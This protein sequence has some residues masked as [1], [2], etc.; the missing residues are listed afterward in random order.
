MSEKKTFVFNRLYAGMLVSLFGSAQAA[1]FDV[2]TVLDT[3]D[4]NPGDGV[5]VDAAGR[6]SLRAAIEESV[7]LGGSH[8]IN[9]AAALVASSDQTITLSE[10]DDGL[11][12]GEYGATAFI[13]GNN[14]TIT[15]NGPTG[16]NGVTVQRTATS[17]T[18]F[19]LF[20]VQPG[21]TLNMF[22]VALGNGAAVGGN[23]GSR[24]AGAGGGAGMGGAIFNQGTV[25]LEGVTLFGNSA[26]GGAGGNGGSAS[27]GGAGGGGAGGN[28]GQSSNNTGGTGGGPNGGN[29][30][31]NAGGDGGGGAGGRGRSG[32]GSGSGGAGGAGGLFGGAGGGG[33]S[34]CTGGGSGTC[35]GGNGGI[36]G[37][38]GGGGGGGS[39][40]SFN[41]TRNVG[42]GGAGG[43][44]GGDGTNGRAN[45][46]NFQPSGDGGG[47][48]GF[49]GAI[50]NYGGSLTVRNSTI[51]GSTATG[52]GSGG[53]TA[54]GAPGG[55]VADGGGGDGF[56]AAIFSMNDGVTDASVDLRHVTVADNI[57]AGGVSNLTPGSGDGGI[58]ILGNGGNSTASLN[59]TIVANTTGGDDVLVNTIAGGT[60]T[61]NGAGNLIE[62]QTGF[63]GTINVSADPDLAGLADNRGPTPTHALNDTSPAIDAGNAGQIG[64]LTTDQRGGIF[65]RV[66]DGNLD[67]SALVDIGA[68]EL[69]QIDYG[70]APDFI[71]GT[72]DAEVLL[73]N[74][75]DDFRISFAG[76]NGDTSRSAFN[77]KVAYNG[78]DD[79]FL[80]VWV[81]DNDATNNDSEVW[82]QR[83]NA[84][85]RMA[86]GSE[87]RISTTGVDGETT[88]IPSDPDVAWSS[89]DNQYLVV[90]RADD[91]AVDNEL[92]IYGRFVGSTGSL[93]GSQL[94]V[95]Q[96]GSGGTNEFALDPKVDYSATSNE[97]L[98]IWRGDEGGTDGLVD[99]EIEI[100]GQRYSSASLTPQGSRMQISQMAGANGDTNFD[101]SDPEITWNSATNQF[102]VIWAADD[103]TGGMV[104]NES[105]IFGRLV[106]GGGVPLGATQTRLTAVG[107]LGDTLSRAYKPNVA[108]NPNANQFLVAFTADDALVSDGE[109][110]IFGQLVT[111][112]TGVPTGSYFQISDAGLAGS[113]SFFAFNPALIY[114][115]LTDNYTVT[116]QA[117]EDVDNE[118]EIWSRR[119][120]S[121]GTV[122]DADEIRISNLGPDESTSFGATNSSIAYSPVSSDGFVV[123]QGDDDTAP[124]VDGETEI[125]GQ[126][127]TDTMFVDYQTRGADDGAAHVRVAGMRMGALTDN[128]PDGLPSIDADGDDNNNLDD[129]DA[130]TGMVE[131][132][133]TAPVITVNLTN[134]SG[135]AATL[136]GWIDYNGDGVFD[137]VTER[138]SVAVPNGTNAADIDLTLPAPPAGAA[139]LTMARFRLSSDPAAADATGLVTGGE[140]EDYVAINNIDTTPDAFA[141]TDQTDVTIN[142]LRTSDAVTLM[143]INSATPISVTGGSFSIN[144]GPF[145]STPDTVFVGDMVTVQHTASASFNST[146]DTVLTVGGVSDTFSSTTEVEDTTPDAFAF[147]DQTDVAVNSLRTSDTIT[148]AG[149]NSTAAISVTGGSYAINGGAFVT[150]PGTVVAGD[151]VTVQHTS[152]ASFND[153]VDTVL[154]I[155]GVSDT[156]TSTTEVED[157]TPD[158]FAFTDQT[159]VALSSLRTSGAVT[160]AGI[161]S[162]AALSVTGGSYSIN[163]GAFVTTPGTV[164]NGDMVVVQHTSSA[165]FNDAVD[166]VL[167][168]GGVSDTF[169]ST[170]EVEDTTPDAFA[171]TDQVDVPLNDLRT[172]DAITVSGINSTAAISV[173]G[174]SYSI[175][176]GAFVTTPGTVV[177]GDMVVAQHT[178]SGSSTTTV[179]TT[180]TIGG[181]ADTFSS[182]TLVVDTMPDAFS[183]TDVVDVTTSTEQTSNAVTITGI[184]SPASISVTGGEYSIDGGPFVTTPG[185]ISSGSTVTVRH[186]S[187]AMFETT[188]DTVLTVGS[189]SDTFS[190]TTQ[191]NPDIIFKNGFE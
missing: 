87:F 39:V 133:D 92:E 96:M 179:D 7:A 108:Y 34:L 40:V 116:F 173:T 27:D 149:I 175:N 119:V 151:M 83:I 86:V 67:G 85:T 155:G 187:S 8:T 49:G 157:T 66:I 171:F 101:A 152:S 19:R 176:G 35:T 183:F 3:V 69:I 70:D 11:D 103:N 13:L 43:F 146:V 122:L 60:A 51:S 128:D 109:N 28:G 37:F 94:T 150:T 125:F 18:D 12:A 159:D 184:N 139:L 172:S 189:V 163:G 190:S 105:E 16:D 50:F 38:G 158:A 185:S 113:T 168:I 63:T 90:W 84:V 45:R 77:A 22:N 138:G 62:N 100:F 177:N 88:R 81:A 98:V 95:S 142:S 58:Y 127:V 143:G 104:D 166:T 135:G 97:F 55:P 99:N 140:V 123:F 20:H 188:V 46:N 71:A 144:G 68:Y 153:A 186:T 162:N 107:G 102:F 178:S 47:G 164:V 174:G 137:N 52:G 160:V 167:T 5:A 132:V 161:N 59:N 131:F 134:T 106:A 118:F 129:E 76:P 17:N 191:I 154:T 33:G 9:F 126:F 72:G 32:A 75:N 64:G 169:T 25:S 48:A 91:E 147:T 30:N 121:A 148:V 23:S 29:P 24:T 54:Y 181:V 156:F 82:G 117:D 36:G 4:A 111:A 14:T 42:V 1:T 79:E 73:E 78:A 31:G 44:G 21:S 93:L 145:V 89:V 182:T 41:Y 61:A 56:G 6:T 80:V 136:Y 115:P 26:T 57:V 110:E 74:G 15:I 130:I 114:N 165:A 65:N 10:V 141:F 124:L 53:L 120:D 180:V 112:S 170:T 2:N